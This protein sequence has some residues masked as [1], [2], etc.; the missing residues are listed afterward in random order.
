MSGRCLQSHPAR[1]HVGLAVI[2]PTPT[3]TP[4]TATPRP[5]LRVRRRL[6]PLTVGLLVWTLLTVATI[7]ACLPSSTPAVTLEGSNGPVR[8]T[9]EVAL[10]REEQEHGLM[11]RDRLE[12]DHGMLFV[13]RAQVMRSFWMKNTPLP[14]DIIFIDRDRKIVSIAEQTKPYSLASIPSGKP[15]KY[16]LEVN[17][18]FSARHGIRPG[19]TVELHHV[20]EHPPAAGSV[21]G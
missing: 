18:G 16:V 14:L 20:P 12:P 3:T 2:D 7:A 13:F 11:W 15:A 9:V 17:G 1:A 21:D 4:T 6:R 10:T 5:A 19:A 8:V